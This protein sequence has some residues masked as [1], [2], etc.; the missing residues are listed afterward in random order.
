MEVL[1]AIRSRR[2]VRAYTNQQV[3][4]PVIEA[5]LNA[6]VQAPSAMNDQPWAFAVIQNRKLLDRL[7][8]EAKTHWL[9]ATPESLAL[10]ALREH[11]RSPDFNVFYDAGTLIVICAQPTGMNPEEDCCLAAQNLM[12]AACSM[13]LATCPIGLARP[14]LNTLEGKL[15]AE[16][17]GDYA[18]VFPVIVGYPRGETGA[19]PRRAPEV[20]AWKH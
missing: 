6:A 12:L 15:L 19:P 13:G 5:L 2:A 9:E 3:D 7:S 17:P 14:V 11:L 18:A 4:R 8:A 20:L 16:I 10:E 1:E